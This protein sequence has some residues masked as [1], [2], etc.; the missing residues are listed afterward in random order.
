MALPRIAERVVSANGSARTHLKGSA[1]THLNDSPRTHVTEVQRTRILSAAVDVVGEDGYWGMSVARVTGRAGVSRRTFYDV[2]TDRE[3]CFL[4]VFQETAERASVIARDAAAGERTWRDRVRAGLSA[5]LQFAGAEPV[6]TSLLVKD[7]LGCG[8][9]VLA[10][11]A[12]WLD[13]LNAI[14]DQGCTESKTGKEPPPLTAEGTVGAVLAV[15][16]ARMLDLDP[17]PPIELLSPLMGMIVLPYLGRAAAA[18]ELAR[19]TPKAPRARTSQPVRPVLD[20]LDMR[21]TYRTLR[22]LSAIAAHPGAS[23]RLVSDTAGVHDQ[24]QIS[25]LLV[26]LSRLG[27]IHNTRPGHPKGEPNAWTLTLA[28]SQVERAV[29]VPDKTRSLAAG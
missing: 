2:F 3:D 20:R 18:K 5:L 25:K 13:T 4:A 15:I 27:L 22:V 23:N 21:L 6:L 12:R 16:H 10:A 29:R 7:A 11:R 26:R 9:L 24:G 1:R 28:G 17:R 19:P 8:P 14:V